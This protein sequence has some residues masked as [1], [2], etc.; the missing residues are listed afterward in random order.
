MPSSVNRR[1]LSAARLAGD[2]IEV[3]SVVSV[4]AAASRYRVIVS[5]HQIVDLVISIT[6]G[7]CHP[8]AQRA[9]GKEQPPVRI[10]DGALIKDSLVTDGCVIG[11]GARVE[12]SILSPGVVVAAGALLRE[13]VVLSGATVVSGALML[14]HQAAEQVRLMTGRPAPVEAMRAALRHALPQS[15]G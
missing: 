5:A 3:R 15:G 9:G 13:S 2:G 8:R 1:S 10:Q 6:V 7:Q 11:P 12:R 4:S 14:L